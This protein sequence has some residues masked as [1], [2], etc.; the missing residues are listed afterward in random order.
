MKEPTTA[1]FALHVAS[2]L[3][4][5]ASAVDAA[6]AGRMNA[7]AQ[8]LL[9]GLLLT[10]PGI[11]R[12]RLSVML[13][14][15]LEALIILFLFASAYLGEIRDCYE[16]FPLWDTALHTLAGFLL[17]AI[18]LSIGGAQEA[19]A[20]EFALFFAFCFSM[21]GGVVWEFWEFAADTLFHLDMQKDVFLHGFTSMKLGGGYI[22]VETVSLNGEPLPG[23]LDIGLYDTMKDLIAG[24]VGAL[25]FGIFAR[26]Y[27]TRRAAFW[28]KQLLPR[29][30]AR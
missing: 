10:L 24:A 6:L 13:P 14:G 18:G 12:R 7:A 29:R 9:A 21:T 28:V 20:P 19:R 3:F 2:R 30:C 16:Q 1:V 25:T 26:M 4:I 5:L 17:A 22:P 27:L 8:C 11:L 23:W 15:T